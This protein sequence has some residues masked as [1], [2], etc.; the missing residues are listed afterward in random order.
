MKSTLEG[1]VA[2]ITGSGRGLGRA[3]AIAMARA[4]ASVVILS[5]TLSELKETEKQIKSLGHNVI[6]QQADVSMPA[7]IS[8]IIDK[9]LF[10]FGRIDV[11]MNNAA[12]IG[13]VRPMHEI[14]KGEWKIAMNIDLH[15]VFFFSQ[16][17]IP[18]M[19][20]Q[21]GGKII[22]VTSGLGEM[23][24]PSFGAYSIAKAGV[25]H[26]T[27][28]LAE[29]LK[30]YNIQVNGLNP[31][32]IDTRMQNEI[33]RLG[34]SVLGEVAYTKFKSLKDKGHLSPP[35]QVAKLAVFLASG[36]SDS[37]TGENGT[38]NHYVP[39]GYKG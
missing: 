39:F 9:T 38:K 7:E 34:P 37:V 26:L 16:E 11:L 25:I 13:P 8:K 35:D 18:S 5:R 17:V 3:S 36:E 31:G 27:R 6:Y 4:G 22:N 24:M 28:F 19:I 2:I 1:K 23:V 20:K 21:G 14:S 33:R 30:R 29:E 12:V 32:V 15:A 10:H